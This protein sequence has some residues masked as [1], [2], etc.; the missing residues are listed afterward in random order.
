MTFQTRWCPRMFRDIPYVGSRT[1]PH[2]CVDCA[3]I[4]F[5]RWARRKLKPQPSAPAERGGGDK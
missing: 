4:L 5:R 3:W 2:W 1:E